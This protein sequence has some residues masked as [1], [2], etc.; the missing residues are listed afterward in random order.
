MY[1]KPCIISQGVPGD[2]L[3]NDCDGLIDEDICC[4][5]IV[6]LM[7][8]VLKISIRAKLEE[9]FIF[10]IYILAFTIDKSIVMVY[11]DHTCLHDWKG[12]F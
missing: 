10:F 5:D 3:D 6:V 12:P 7:I 11:Y 1:Y 9:G 8:S 2:G 4:K